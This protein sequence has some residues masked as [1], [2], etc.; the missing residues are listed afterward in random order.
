MACERQIPGIATPEEI[1]YN[2]YCSPP[3]QFVRYLSGAF[4]I[5]GENMDKQWILVFDSG[6]GGISV[7]RELMAVLPH[8]QF[9]YVGDSRNA[10]Y[11]GRSTQEVRQLTLASVEKFMA[12]RP[13]KA[14]VVACNTAT[15]AA[16]DTLRAAY[17]ERIIVGMEPAVKLAADQHPGGR[18]IVMAT[19]VTL[20]EA[21][22]CALLDRFSGEQRIVPLPC[23]GLVEFIEAGRLHDPA[24]NRHLQD[25]LSPALAGGADAIVLGCTHF[26]FLKP[27]IR[28][29]AGPEVDILDGGHGTAMQT[30]HRL[31]EKQLLCSSG[32]GTVEL[33]NSL[34]TPEILRLS[35][36]LL[37]GET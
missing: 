8:E 32:Q 18:I 28:A 33:H 34:G 30:L 4:D 11:G 2:A 20:R 16:I 23:P 14:V 31:A 3:R 19:Q 24:L 26:P 37:H 25:L 5:D 29:L 13:V 35:A 12:D 6:L 27:M 9:L 36:A 21:K 22:F 15:A 17:P 10:P 7:L 1:C